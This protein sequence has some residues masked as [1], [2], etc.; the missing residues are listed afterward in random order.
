MLLWLLT[1]ALGYLTRTFRAA[2]VLACQSDVVYPLNPTSHYLF[3]FVAMTSV[4]RNKCIQIVPNHGPS[5]S[6]CSGWS[7]E[8]APPKPCFPLFTTASIPHQA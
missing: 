3:P 4:A 5:L 6:T 1:Q 7:P 2:G 8:T